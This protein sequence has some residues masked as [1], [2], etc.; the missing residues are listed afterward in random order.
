MGGGSKGNS[1]SHRYLSLVSK[2][3]WG[4][5][6]QKCIQKIMNQHTRVDS[7]IVTNKEQVS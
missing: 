4:A 1:K 7:P 3:D 6:P 5:V 2:G